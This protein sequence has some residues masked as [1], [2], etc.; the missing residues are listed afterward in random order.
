MGIPTYTRWLCKK[1]P[2][3]LKQL[4]GGNGSSQNDGGNDGSSSSSA[5]NR[6]VF[7]NFY[8]DM[9]G[10]IHDCAHGQVLSSIPRNEDDV[11]ENLQKCRLFCLFSVATSIGLLASVNPQ[12]LLF[13]SV[14]GVAPRAR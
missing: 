2:L 8:I 11:F 10:I 12:K 5:R 14:D 7:D 3:I 6:F 4:T 1:Y 13:M 9:N